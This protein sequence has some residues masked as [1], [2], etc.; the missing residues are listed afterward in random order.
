LGTANSI[1]CTVDGK[2]PKQI[3]AD[4]DSGVVTL[5]QA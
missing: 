1:G 4:I 2:K 5:P 3:Q